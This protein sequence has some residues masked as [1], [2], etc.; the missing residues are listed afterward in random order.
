MTLTHYI[1][2]NLTRI[3][4]MVSIDIKK[5]YQ[6]MHSIIGKSE[7]KIGVSFPDWNDKEIGEKIRFFGPEEQL[8]FIS[9]SHMLNDY[10]EN[11]LIL[12]SRIKNIPDVNKYVRFYRNRNIEKQGNAYFQRIQKR[13]FQYFEKNRLPFKEIKLPQKYVTQSVFHNVTMKSKST[14]QLSF[15][16]HIMKETLDK[17]N[18]DDSA[19]F[20]SY[21]LCRSGMGVPDF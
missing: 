21:G 14:N 18:F 4:E 17:K 1:E 6:K 11:G 20:S 10:V 7:G 3:A 13:S 5:I 16:I 15:G 12:M 2:I 8:Q 9:R 19:K